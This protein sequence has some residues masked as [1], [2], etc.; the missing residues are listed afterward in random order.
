MS[1]QWLY[2]WGVDSDWHIPVT[3]VRGT[4]G[5]FGVVILFCVSIWKMVTRVC[6]LIKIHCTYDRLVHFSIYMLYVVDCT[7]A[8]NPSLSLYGGQSTLPCPTDVG[9]GQ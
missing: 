3:V 5:I 4:Q 6:H 9:F 7:I 8:P 1:E 2:C